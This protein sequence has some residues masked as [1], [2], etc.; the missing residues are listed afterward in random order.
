MPLNE[1]QVAAYAK[2]EDAVKEISEVFEFSREG[3]VLAG[4]VLAVNGVKF[5][6]DHDCEWH[7]DLSVDSVY[8]YFVRR[9]Q[10]H[11]LTRGIIESTLDRLRQPDSYS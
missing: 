4:W 6:T 7:D 8:G 5:E 10:Q 2:L 9:G 3:E 1:K 11:A